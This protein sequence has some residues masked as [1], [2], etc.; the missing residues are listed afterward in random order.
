MGCGCAKPNNSI[1]TTLNIK[2]MTCHHCVQ[3]VKSA[4][5]KVSSV[6]NVNVDLASATATILHYDVEGIR[7][8]FVEAVEKAGYEVKE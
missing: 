1:T 8:K 5:E 7:D 2:G 3:A 6:E 4:L